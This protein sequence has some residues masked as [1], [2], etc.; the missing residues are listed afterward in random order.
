[1]F[2][3]T[4]RESE[5]R[6]KQQVAHRH[7]AFTH[8]LSH[9]NQRLPASYYKNHHSRHQGEHYRLPPSL[10]DIITMPRAHRESSR[11]SRS[12]SGFAQYQQRLSLDL[13]ILQPPILLRES[14]YYEQ[15]YYQPEVNID[16]HPS[17]TM[18]I[19]HASL[20]RNYTHLNLAHEDP[21]HYYDAEPDY[22]Q[23][24]YYQR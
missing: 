10:L 7:V 19:P 3:I 24:T 12:R 6:E 15:D 4:R 8:E 5:R 9:G 14:S 22:P 11:L 17:M 21:R 2:S 13:P 1:M 16:Q 18:R 20:T 23:Y